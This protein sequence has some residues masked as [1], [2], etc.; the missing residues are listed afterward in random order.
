MNLSDNLTIG[1]SD[2]P[3]SAFV[4]APVTRRSVV[5]EASTQLREAILGGS[6]PVGTVLPS[7]AKLAASLSV[8]RPV[9]RE[10]LG[11]LRALGLVT[12]RAGKGWEVTSDHV[13]SG[14]LLAGAYLSEHLHEVRQ[15]LEVPAAG[16]AAL[17]HKDADITRLHDIL[18][19]E[20]SAASPRQAV[21]LDA[22]FHIGIARCSGNPLLASLVEFIR[23]GLVEQSLALSTVKGRSSR[24]VA[25]HFTILAAVE[26]RDQ[27]A[28]EDAMRAHLTAVSDAVCSLSGAGLPSAG[29]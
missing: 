12:P 24:A 28:A 1:Q 10:A 8:S 18:E 23:A 15:H 17:R 6:L 25:E 13:G 19:T 7:E 20:R 4:P 2:K 21:D 11:S 14:L 16:R 27:S 22:A 9:I 29:A 26:S 5:D 3:A